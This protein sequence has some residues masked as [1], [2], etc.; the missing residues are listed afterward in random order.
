MADSWF[1]RYNENQNSSENK[2]GNFAE[3]FGNISEPVQENHQED[4]QKNNLEDKEGDKNSALSAMTIN[5]LDSRAVDADSKAGSELNQVSAPEQVVSSSYTVHPAAK[6]VAKPEEDQTARNAIVNSNFPDSSLKNISSQPTNFDSNNLKPNDSF[7]LSS[8]KKSE[9]NLKSN[10]KKTGQKPTIW[11]YILTA[12]LTAVLVVGFMLAGANLG[13][14]HITQ[15]VSSI[16]DVTKLQS[17]KAEQALSNSTNENPDWEKIYA[18]VAPSVVSIE[19]TYGQSGQLGSGFIIDTAGHIVTNNHVVTASGTSTITVTLYDGRIYGAKVTG[20]DP[21]SDL[22]VIQLQDGP[23][24]LKPVSFGDSNSLTV[25]DSVIAVGNPLG[26]SNTATTGVISSLDRP[27]AVQSESEGLTLTPSSSSDYV[28]TNAIQTDAAVN[29]GNSGGP[30]FNAKGEVIGVNSSIASTGSSS[31]SGSTSGSIGIGFAI[32]AKLAQRVANEIVS[33]GKATHAGLGVT[34]T[35][36]SV[37][38]DGVERKGVELK[39]VNNGMP[40]QVAGLK[41]GDIV[42]SIDNKAVQSDYSLMG[43]IREYALN[44]TIKVGY[45]RD[46]KVYQVDVKLDKEQ[47]VALGTS[48]SNNNSDN[49]SD[50]SDND[51]GDDDSNQWDP[52]GLF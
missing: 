24:D 13:W 9:E 8:D 34:I 49:G 31:S 16:S 42:V 47:S 38:V 25:G 50:N 10:Q 35:T 48:N 29:P 36:A 12:V 4:N 43:Y 39:T 33:T 6:Q 45:V 5:I 3:G 40:A 27:V 19:V 14:F 7:T 20:T 46:G 11:T 51:N 28:V 15:K 37:K 44:S 30:L 22:A 52:F 32:P 23:D 41:V 1:D 2:D 21:T 18:V 17:D 26:L